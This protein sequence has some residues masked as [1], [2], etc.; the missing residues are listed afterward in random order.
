MNQYRSTFACIVILGFALVSLAQ[1][2]EDRNGGLNIVPQPVSSKRLKGSFKLNRETRLYA[3]DDEAHRIA[4]FFNDYLVKTY[5][6]KLEYKAGTPTVNDQNFILFTTEGRNESQLEGYQLSVAAESVKVVGQKA[7]LFY[8]AQ[9]LMQLLTLGPQRVG[10]PQVE[11][12]DYPRFRYRGMHLDV[13]RHFFPVEF[14]K[15]YLDLM[16]QYKMNFFHWHLTEDQGW[17]IEIKKYPTLAEIGGRRK[18]TVKDQ[19]LYPY[20][21]DGIP[22]AGYYTQEQIKDVVAYAQERFITIVPEIEMPGHSLA[23]LAAYPEL[24]CTGGPFEVATNWGIYKDIYCPKEET[25]EFLEDVLTE[26]VALFPGPYVHIG[27]DEAPKRRWKES[28]VAQAVMRREGLKDEE[29]LQGYF[30]RRI[31]S[32]LNS[33]GKRVIGWDEI[34]A[35]GLSTDATVMS[36][37]GMQGGIDAAQQKHEA[38]MTPYDFCYFDYNQGDIKRE[39]L[40]IGSYTPLSKVYS[41]NPMPS[42]LR[43]EE[44]KYIIGAQGNVWT[45][46]MKTPE[47]VE[48]MVFPRLLALSEAVW[49]PNDKKSYSEFLR[50]LPYQLARL[51]QEGVNYRI[52][53][54]QGL[55][56]VLTVNDEKVDLRLSPPFAGNKIYYTLDGSDPSELSKL[57]RGPL[58]VNLGREQKITFNTVV[59]T[60][61]GKRSVVFSTTLQRRPFVAATNYITSQPGVKYTL[62]DG[63]FGSVKEIENSQSKTNGVAASFDLAQFNKQEVYGLIFE[64]YLK[65]PA[66]DIYRFAT[67]SDDGSA[68]F[69]DGEEVVNNDGSHGMQRVEGMIPLRKGF[70]RITLKFF[71]GYGGLGLKV[72]WAHKG[73]DLIP[74]ASDVLFH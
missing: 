52:Q 72:L 36:W 7:G 29:Q 45:E 40:N 35:G 2:P 19:N 30:M 21:G 62:F 11:I 18:E 42:E 12:T 9:T 14:I 57:Y 32:F 66:D 28:E 60:P 1:V 48:Y 43:P 37:H 47:K 53:E 41:F 54:P 5:G 26:V 27:G 25:F 33:K 68:L 13:G 20:I 16:A 24:A 70:H 4:G 38:I 44:Q 65:V 64:G 17:R 58:R 55:Q 61:S 3:N 71:Q 50:R 31:E 63:H 49:S 46:Y 10:I 51:E 8:G 69:I 74:V 56:N 39:P 59:I 73:Q 6:F 23:A 34:L 22:H 15:K 67:D